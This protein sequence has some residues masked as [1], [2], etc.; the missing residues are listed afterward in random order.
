MFR[1]LGFCLGSA[2]SI[3][4]LLV[5]IGMPELTLDGAEDDAARFGAAIE[6]L[7]ARQLAPV[8]GTAGDG[9]GTPAADVPLETAPEAEST[10]AVATMDTVPEEDGAPDAPAASQAVAFAEP[11]GQPEWHEFWTPFASEIAARGFVGRLEAVTGLDYRVTRIRPG[12]Y[13]VSFA[14]E[15]SNELDGKLSQI[16]AATGLDV[17]DT[18]P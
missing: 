15:D 8:A 11:D 5:A 4:L 17:A 10:V 6:K 2:V 12:Q 18:L 3:G 7:K 9:D 1:L 16:A 14:Y 13:Q